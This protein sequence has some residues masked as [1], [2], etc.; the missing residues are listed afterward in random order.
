ML[1]VWVSNHSTARW[2]RLQTEAYLGI[3]SDTAPNN[4]PGRLCRQSES[5]DYSAGLPA[6][7]PVAPIT[8]GSNLLGAQ[9]A[10]AYPIVA[11]VI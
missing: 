10:I 11:S 1:C 4:Q 8:Y 2:M 9:A 6:T 5:V 3:Y 7:A